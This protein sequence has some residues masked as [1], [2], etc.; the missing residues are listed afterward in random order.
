MNIKGIIF[1]L[2]GTLLY[3]LE[4]LKNSVNYAL[5]H[6]GLKE[7][8]L[9]EIRNF[10]G[11]GIYKLIERA[12]SENPCKTEECF[13]IFK[14]HYKQNSTNTTKPYDGALDFLKKLKEKGVKLAVLSNKIDSEVK[15]LTKI[16]FNNIFDYCLGQTR[17][18]AKKPQADGVYYI[19]EKLGLKKENI[20]FA[21]DSEVDIKCAQNAEIK[22]LSVLW[23]Y[24]DKEFLAKNGAEHLFSDFD[25]L[26]NYLSEKI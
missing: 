23:G 16:Y 18:L 25:E 5:K 10:V 21:G 15:K 24:K 22:C 12:T 2:D 8:T 1:D 11:D 14:E 9:D 19:I 17:D 4:D 3:T 26:Y 7:R 6:C 20:I 13:K